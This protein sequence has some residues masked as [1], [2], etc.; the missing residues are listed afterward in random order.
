MSKF[1]LA[2]GP[3]GARLGSLCR[4]S[5]RVNMVA[6]Q[7][8]LPTTLWPES[9]GQRQLQGAFAAPYLPKN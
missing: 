6:I 2:G 9:T 3:D 1:H 5:R 4:I 8:A 7:L